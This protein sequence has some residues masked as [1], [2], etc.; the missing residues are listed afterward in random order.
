MLQRLYFTEHNA[1]FIYQHND[2]YHF[3]LNLFFASQWGW[4]EGTS[5]NGPIWSVS[6]E[7][8]LYLIFFFF[9]L[10]LYR[11]QWPLCAAVLLG[12]IMR[13]FLG[14]QLGTAL[15]TFFI[16]GLTFQ[17]VKYFSQHSRTVQT[18]AFTLLLI[19]VI[20]WFPVFIELKTAVFEDTWLHIS[21]DIFIIGN[22]DYAPTIYFYIARLYPYIFLFPLTIMLLVFLEMKFSKLNWRKAEVFGSLTYSTYLLHF[23]LQLVFVMV[24]DGLGY[25]RSIYLPSWTLAV[26]FLLLIPLCFLTFKYVEDPLKKRIRKWLL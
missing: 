2:L 17:L 24:T 13:V 9:S 21:A 10:L 15:S 22:K 7:V 14:G 20:I 8:L 19:L 1:F 6:L 25:G 16:G 11:A 18:H 3:F 5:F 4:Q 12:V 23:P 26:F